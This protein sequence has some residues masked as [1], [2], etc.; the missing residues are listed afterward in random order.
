MDPI[1]NRTTR[2]QN[3]RKELQ[4]LTEKGCK[5]GDYVEGSS[6]KSSFDFAKKQFCSTLK[7]GTMLGWMTNQET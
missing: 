3:R 6:I 4:A 1:H 7:V 5:A 2:Q